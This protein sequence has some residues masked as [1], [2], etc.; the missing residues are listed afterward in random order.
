MYQ[1][2][3]VKPDGRKLW[4]YSRWPIDARLTA[5]SPGSVALNP[6]P[7]FRWHPFRG[8]WITY[9]SHRQDR[10]F[11]PP[12]EYNPLAVTKDAANPTE[13]PLGDYDIAVFQN[14]FPSL[15]Q[16]AHSAPEAMVATMPATGQCEVVVFTQDA[17]SKLSA[18]PLS[19]IELL[20]EVWGERTRALG[21]ESNIQYV[22]PFENRGV[23]VG[24]TLH[25]PHGQ[26][27]AYP[28]VPPVPKRM[29]SQEVAHYRQ[30]RQAMLEHY[31]E[32][33]LKEDARIVYAGEHAIAFLPAWARYPYEIWL[34]PIKAVPDFSALGA[35]QR[36]DLARALKTVLKKYDALWDRPFPYLMAWYQAPTDGRAHP[37][38][39]LHAEFYPPYRTRDKLKFLA[40]TELAAG[41]F[42]SDALPED[43]AKDLQAIQVSI[44]D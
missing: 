33:E 20:F 11:M 37:E 39:H 19:H 27:Y 43:K 16:A 24:V 8:E 32:R 38:A 9:A 2:E 22:L 7:H 23:E 28:F 41:M 34:A 13:L 30:N 15:A 4:L 29:Q 5:P 44:D 3:L 1:R 14:R 42:A 35:E 17:S 10:T 21:A 36:A 6:N 12:P 25:H 26:I 40:G 31:I 18:L